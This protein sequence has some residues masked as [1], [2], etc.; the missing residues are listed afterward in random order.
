MQLGRQLSVP[1]TDRKYAALVQKKQEEYASKIE[2]IIKECGTRRTAVD[3]GAYVGECSRIIAENFLDVIAFEPHH[4]AYACLVNN[5]SLYSNIQTKR[6]ALSSEKS[7]SHIHEVGENGFGDF[8]LVS[9]PKPGSKRTPVFSIDDLNIKDLDFIRISS[10]FESGKVL[11]G[12]VETI[13]KYR[14]VIWIAG[15]PQAITI[16]AAM[17]LGSLGYQR[18][19]RSNLYASIKKTKDMVDQAD[20][21]ILIAGKQNWLAV[22]APK[23]A[24]TPSDHFGAMLDRL[25][26]PTTRYTCRSNKG[27]GDL[28][29]VGITPSFN[30]DVRH[31]LRLPTE[32]VVQIKPVP[33]GAIDTAAAEEMLNAKLVPGAIELKLHWSAVAR[34]SHILIEAETE[35]RERTAIGKIPIS[36]LANVEDIKIDIPDVLL[37]PSKTK[38]FIKLYASGL[39]APTIKRV[40]GTSQAKISSRTARC[41]LNHGGGGN[42]VIKAMAEGLQ[43]PLSYAEDG[44]RSG[45]PIVWGVLRG[46]REVLLQAEER[47]RLWMYIDHAYFARGHLANYRISLNRFEAG[48][49]RACPSDRFDR[50]GIDIAP[51]KTGGQDIL[52]CPPT[53]HF[54][55]AHG[56]ES[57]LDDTL[58][59]LAKY[60][61][62]P[63]IVR[64]KP[65]PGETSVPLSEA[66]QNAYALVTHSSNVAIEAAVAG[67]PVYVSPTSAAAPVGSTSLATIEHRAFPDRRAWLQHLAYSQFSFDEIKSGQAIDILLKHEEMPLV[68]E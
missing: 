56:V 25:Y 61:D 24:I 21:A 59:E 18:I 36:A 30:T 60:T 4:E 10:F 63:V 3:V 1:N 51:W 11:T 34:F 65:Q 42:D 12:A 62:R 53:Q 39:T 64:Q 8:R 35:G 43:C 29:V 44:L 9:K 16:D 67:V 22:R 13:Y 52:V 19:G 2:W 48:P 14:P 7:I 5:T 32:D 54:I 58:A 50:L 37:S 17:H 6:L 28:L 31:K 27:I 57:W 66:L 15:E 49:V 55:K 40:L 20:E 26:I 47:D 41:Y 68:T 46:S 23:K 45:V 33:A 38:I